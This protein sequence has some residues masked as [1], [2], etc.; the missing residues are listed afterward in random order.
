MASLT[1]TLRV[2]SS[3]PTSAF[4]PPAARLSA[5]VWPR[6]IICSV[7]ACCCWRSSRKLTSATVSTT[8]D[9]M[10]RLSFTF[11]D[12]CIRLISG[13]SISLGPD[14]PAGGSAPAYHTRKGA[15][16]GQANL[17]P[18]EQPQHAEPDGQI[19]DGVGER[20][21]DGGGPRREQMVEEPR[22]KRDE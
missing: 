2:R 20:G 9:V 12:S 5:M 1:R 3:L 14:A 11:S 18:I 22:V 19:G 21:V 7:R 4:L 6:L 17:I 10:S 13:D 8:R 16:H 15:S